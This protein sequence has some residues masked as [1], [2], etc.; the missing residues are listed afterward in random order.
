MVIIMFQKSFYGIDNY[1]NNGKIGISANVFE[2][3]TRLIC[4]EIDGVDFA[5]DKNYLFRKQDIICKFKG[6]GCHIIINLRVKYGYNVEKVCKEV[7]ERV[8][9]SLQ[10]MTEVTPTKI[11]IF[12]ADVR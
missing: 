11:D 7:R 10:Y 5:M 2:E 9:Q 12:I 8:T 3:I 4:L 1:K 6:D